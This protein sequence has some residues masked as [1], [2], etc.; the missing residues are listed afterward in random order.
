MNKTSN[1]FGI[2]SLS[3]LIALYTSVA[4]A[5]NNT[6][7]NNKEVRWSVQKD[8]HVLTDSDIL[9][10]H[11]ANYEVFPNNGTI[12]GPIVVVTPPDLAEL[13][14]WLNALPQSQSKPIIQQLEKASPA[15]A[16]GIIGTPYNNRLAAIRQ[17]LI[18]RGTFCRLSDG[19]APIGFDGQNYTFPVG[20]FPDVANEHGDFFMHQNGKPFHKTPANLVSD[21]DYNKIKSY[22]SNPKYVFRVCWRDAPGHIA[23]E[24]TIE[25]RKVGYILPGDYAV[26]ITKNFEI[27]D[28]E[29]RKSVFTYPNEWF[30]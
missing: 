29:T 18:S 4:C 25:M 12:T 22:A 8:T 13:Q 15:S 11:R 27:I 24:K 26:E 23:N 28:T 14:K 16:M 30:F 19:L 9:I 21:S 2:A 7:Q 10:L 5:E 17:A 20:M 3:I 6:Y 1:I